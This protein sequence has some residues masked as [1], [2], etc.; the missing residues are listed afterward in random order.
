MFMLVR[1]LIGY[2]A[3]KQEEGVGKGKEKR[4]KKRGERARR[5]GGKGEEKG[6]KGGKRKKKTAEKTSG[7]FPN[8]Y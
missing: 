5:E 3:E 1:L 4:Q 7:R 8:V 2:W 6:G